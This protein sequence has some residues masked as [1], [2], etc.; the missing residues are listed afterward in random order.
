MGRIWC[1]ICPFMIYGEVLQTLSLKIRPR[2]LRPWP[3][4]LAERWG[5]GCSLASLL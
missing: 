3:R 1:A 2:K 4:Q 5:V